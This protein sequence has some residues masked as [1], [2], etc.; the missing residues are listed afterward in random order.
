[1]MHKSTD[2]NSRIISYHILKLEQKV[3]ILVTE[4]ALDSSITSAKSH[5]YDSIDN[6]QSNQLKIYVCFIKLINAIKMNQKSCDCDCM[7]LCY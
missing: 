6:R 7:L 5:I 2:F 3:D 4:I 1:M